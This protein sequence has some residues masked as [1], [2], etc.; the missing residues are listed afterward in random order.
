MVSFYS[1]KSEVVAEVVIKKSR[2]IAWAVPAQNIEEIYGLLEKAR[3]LWPGATH[4]CYAYILRGPYQ[5]KYSDDGEPAGTAGLPILNIIKYHDLTDVLV[6]V[7]RYFGGVLLGASG[8]IR[9]YSSAASAAL[10]KAE[11]QI[12]TP[13]K[14][15]KADIDYIYWGKIEYLCSLENILV[16]RTIFDASVKADFLV[17]LY[18]VEKFVQNLVAIS[19]GT[20]LIQVG[21]TEYCAF[22]KEVHL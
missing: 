4:Y 6:I 20:A 1:I 2:F 10:E 8:L 7:V 19:R 9:A 11:K 17:P 15:L 13:C 16:A 3:K 22:D 14:R 12:F 21:E 18:K 5:E